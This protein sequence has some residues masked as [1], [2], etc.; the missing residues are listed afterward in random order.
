MKPATF[1]SGMMARWRSW[2]RGVRHRD[3]LDTEMEAELQSHLES[4]T[5][6]LLRA[7]LPRDEAA[8]QAHVAL[9]P[10]LAHKEDMRA[11][12]GL[13]WWDEIGSDVRYGARMLVKSPGF[14]AIAAISLA[15]AI[16]AN[17]AIFSVTKQLLFERLAVPH[18]DN[19]RLLEWTGTES[20]SAVHNVWGSW[21]PL[22]GGMARST[23]FSY[24]AF[25]QLRADNRVLE[26]LFAFKD[27]GVNVNLH[28]EAM[29]LRVEMVSGNFYQALGVRPVL[30]RALQP[31]DEGGPGQNPVAVI[32]YGLWER[33]FGKSPSVLGQTIHVNGAPLTI[34]GVNP[35]EFTGARNVQ[36]SPEIFL[37]LT[38]QPQ[39]WPMQLP[40]ATSFSSAGYGSALS[41]PGYWWVTI[42]GRARPGVSGLA[43]QASLNGDL[44]AIVRTTMPIKKGEDIPQLRL[45]DGSRGLFEQQQMFAK[46]MAVLMTFVGFVLLLAC[47]NVANLLLAR[48]AR[49]QREMS[50]RL[51]LG[52]GRFRVLRQMLIESLM[53]AALGGVGGLFAGYLG[54]ILI[55]K[56][57]ENAWE[58]SDFHV[59]FDWKIFAFT[60]GVTLL[61]GLLFGIAPA[62]AAARAE[63]ANGLKDGSQTATRRRKGMASKTL[64]AFQIALST[65]LVIGAGLFLRTL[66]DLNSVDVGFRTDHLLLAEINPPRSSYPPGKDVDLHRR[67]EESLAAIPGMKSVSAVSVPYV[68][69]DNDRSDFIIEGESVKDDTTQA[70][71]YNVVGTR[72]FETMGIPILAGRGFDARDTASSP[73]V[74]VINQALARQRFGK[75][76]P[77]GKRFARDFDDKTQV[78]TEWIEIVGVCGDTRYSDL[79]TPPPPQYMIPFIQQREVGAMTYAIRTATDPMAVVPSLR[80]AVR[81]LDPNLPPNNDLRT[82]EQQIDAAMQQERIFVVLTSGFGVLAL[83]L[84][85]IGI[86]GIMAYSVN[87]RTNEFGIR[88]AMGARREQMRAMILRESS[89][90][91]MVGIAAGVGGALLFTRAIRSMLYGVSPER[92]SN[93]RRRRGTV[94]AVRAA[95]Q[96]DSRNARR[97][98]RAHPGAA[99]RVGTGEERDSVAGKYRFVMSCHPERSEDAQRRRRRGICGLFALNRQQARCPGSRDFRD[100]GLSAQSC[101][102]TGRRR[103]AGCRPQP[104]AIALRRWD[105]REHSGSTSDRERRRRRG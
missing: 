67:L 9:G 83:L 54:S 75:Q 85:A 43:A 48:G 22:P 94:V 100:P 91:A 45:I 11:S 68:A 18:A 97:Q 26:E 41:L 63:V 4:L 76:N 80:Q 30:G 104:R 78:P 71:S 5:D 62:L 29:R 35:P 95:G 3:T 52:A 92:P 17:T 70:E 32:S 84:A 31:S 19:L 6:D 23:S 2:W 90:L 12:Y 14:T 51:A 81:Q 13:R 98:G 58:R 61:T 64:V 7:G 86:Y 33:E 102:R 96:L 53:L 37:P 25:V 99:A 77:I 60:A 79:R 50:V 36:Q 59:H 34:V 56:M 88:L 87:Q 10:M 55:P 24:P 101:Q 40:G 15:L 38:M 74:A 47:A 39:V 93:A 21:E 89:T 73:K 44:Q 105:C 20:H 42:M 27:T 46:P 1:V 49:R 66:R 28:G 72:F 82:Q 65:L 57:T 103:A 16:G 69:D 8:R